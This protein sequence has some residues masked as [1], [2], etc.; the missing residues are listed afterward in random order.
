MNELDK[1]TLRIIQV[2]LMWSAVT[3]IAWVAVVIGALIVGK[4]RDRKQ[5]KKVR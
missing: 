2:V 3:F 4:S 1:I 5:G